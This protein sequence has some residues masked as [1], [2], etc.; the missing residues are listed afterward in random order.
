MSDG[1]LKTYRHVSDESGR[2]LDQH[3]CSTCGANI[4]FMLEA[5]PGIRTI[6]GGTFDDPSWVD[7]AKH[8]FRHVF[9]RSVQKWCEIPK[10]VDQYEEHFR[11]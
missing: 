5:V 9:V 4:G 1:L 2:W 8:Q 11:R 3:F 6:A 7:A 10:G